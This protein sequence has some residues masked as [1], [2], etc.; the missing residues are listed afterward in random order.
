M[1]EVYKGKVSCTN[2]YA[3]PFEEDAKNPEIHFLDHDYVESMYYMHKKISA[4]ERIVG[5]YSTAPRIRPADLHLDAL[6]R[7]L[8]FAT[9]RPVM[10][11]IDVRPDVEGLPVQA[12][13]SVETVV[14]GREN[15]RTFA[16]L[17][18]DVG[19]SEAEEVGVEHLLRDI[20]DPS[21]SSTAAE[22]R[23]KLAGLKGLRANLAEISGYLAAVTEGKLPANR[24]VLYHVQMLLAHLPNTQLPE[25]TTAM[26]E[27]VNDQHLVIYIAS[28]TRAVLA[29]HDAL[30]NRIKFREAEE[31]AAAGGEKKDDAAA[32]AGAG[33]GAGDK[34]KKDEKKEGAKDK[35]SK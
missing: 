31:A 5:F 9:P 30:N 27:T 16:H 34:D 24:D 17:P 4:R 21:V 1:G 20:N 19:A 6:F 11:L 15:V 7:R 14:E 2:S 26:F 25:V 10:V 28:L 12:Y 13:Q 32:G 22:L 8:P 35:E 23:H 18:C 33:A 3:V 29:L